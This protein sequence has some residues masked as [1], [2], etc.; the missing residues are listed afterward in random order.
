MSFANYKERVGGGYQVAIL[1][2]TKMCLR[3][4]RHL[5]DPKTA[6]CPRCDD[7]LQKVLDACERLCPRRSEE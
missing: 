7:P 4:R 6:A 3:C 5:L 1:P 2:G